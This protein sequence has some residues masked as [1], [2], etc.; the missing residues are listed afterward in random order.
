MADTLAK[1]NNA[2]DTK[3]MSK[4]MVEFK[5]QNKMIKV[6][7]ELLNNVLADEFNKSN[8]EEE[9]DMVTGQ[10]LTEIGMELDEKM[11]GF[12]APS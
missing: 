6:K 10:V 9:V 3:K 1:A 4:V 5:R 12:H 2:M 11:V 8:L 7:E